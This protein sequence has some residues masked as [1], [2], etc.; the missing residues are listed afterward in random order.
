[1]GVTIVRGTVLVIIDGVVVE[2]WEVIGSENVGL[3]EVIIILD[4]VEIISGRVDWVV[5]CKLNELGIF[6]IEVE[7][8]NWVVS[9]T[10][11][12]KV[13]INWEEF[14]NVEIVVRIVR[15]RLVPEEII[16]V[17]GFVVTIW[18][19]LELVVIWEVL[20]IEVWGIVV[21]IWGV[22]ELVIIWE[23]PEDVVVIWGVENMG[24]DDK[25]TVFVIR[26]EDVGK[27]TE[28]V[29]GWVDLPVVVVIIGVDK[30]VWVKEGK[31]P[32]LDVSEAL[33]VDVMRELVWIDWEEGFDWRVDIEIPEVVVV[34]D[35]WGIVLIMVFNLE[36]VVWVIVLKGGRVVRLVIGFEV[37]G[38][39][40]P[41]A[42]RLAVVVITGTGSR[43]VDK[44]V[45]NMLVG[46]VVVLIDK[47]VVVNVFE[48]DVTVPG[49]DACEDCN[50]EVV[51]KGG[52]IDWVTMGVFIIDIEDGNWELST[53]PMV[54]VGVGKVG[55]KLVGKNVVAENNTDWYCILRMNLKKLLFF[56]AFP[57]YANRFHTI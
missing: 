56:N 49:V 3:C 16:E 38:L 47:V 7:V 17:W 54:V 57:I 42:G 14:G 53:L 23:V 15:I 52:F 26:L 39:E 21:T 37:N 1:M 48:F 8:G 4:N 34:I 31:V 19:V 12:G 27:D 20:E 55:G 44:I 13:D 36:V 29:D 33:N 10:V 30:I 18:E 22:L 24:E 35:G 25:G 43:E 5:D 40:G 50:I 2:N 51:V 32:I 6:R 41:L 46:C 11:L 9:V 45:D 28:I